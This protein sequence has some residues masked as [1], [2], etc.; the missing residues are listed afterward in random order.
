LANL[1]QNKKQNPN[2]NLMEPDYTPSK[3]LDNLNLDGD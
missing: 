3:D 2:P 1:I